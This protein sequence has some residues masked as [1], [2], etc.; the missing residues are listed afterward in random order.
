MLPPITAL[1]D[2]GVPE[3]LILLV[4]IVALLLLGPTKIPQLARGIGK[5]LG[6]FR[7]GR[8]EI[9]NEISRS[10][11]SESGSQYQPPK[12]SSSI[13]QAAEELGVSTRDRSER[14]IKLEIVRAIDREAEQRI[15]AAAKILGVRTENMG[16]ND[17]KMQI[18]RTIGI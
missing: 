14:D 9:E 15:L 8:Q 17:V 3:M 2:V 18:I 16:I 10:M 4:I 13:M 11:A 12:S 1:L 7:R 6:E 5:A